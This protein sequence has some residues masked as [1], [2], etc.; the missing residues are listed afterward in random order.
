MHDTEG[1]ALTRHRI[2]AMTPPSRSP[3]AGTE[4]GVLDRL[5]TLMPA[6][7]CL[8]GCI[9]PG[10]VDALLPE[11]RRHLQGMSAGRIAEFAAGRATARRALGMLGFSGHALDRRQDRSPVWPNGVVGSLSHAG[12]LS[13][14]A[15]ARREAIFGIG[16]DIE[17]IGR[18]RE[19]LWPMVF[20]SGEVEAIESRPPTER[21]TLASILFSA[22]EAYF[23][24]EYPVWGEWLDFTDVTARIVSDSELI[25]APLKESR[26]LPAQGVYAVADDVVCVCV[27]EQHSFEHRDVH[28]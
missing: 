17:R 13:V 5:R 14:A 15:V 6:T 21:A 1:R 28:L 27:F 11:E 16:I 19:K 2:R 9:G 26:V 25:L 10:S 8:S 12:A 22:K 4:P 20:V 3:A 23:K 18:V 7:V 24:F